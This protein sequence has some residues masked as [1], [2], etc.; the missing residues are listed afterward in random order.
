MAEAERLTHLALSCTAYDK[1]YQR[2]WDPA[3]GTP[4]TY[5]LVNR[6]TGRLLI[7]PDVLER[8][9][10]V[11]LGNGVAPINVRSELLQGERL[12]EERLASK[13][14][15]WAEA[16]L[17]LLQ[18]LTGRAD[19]TTAYA[20][21]FALS[22][23]GYAFGSALDGLRPLAASRLATAP[24]LGAAIALLTSKRPTS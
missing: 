16:D 5:N 23:P 13:G 10:V 12:I 20:P 15:F 7:Q 14:N 8:D 4:A 2:E 9:E 22:P 21:F 3:H 1:G 6:L 18:V 17:A 11:D 19:A 24:A